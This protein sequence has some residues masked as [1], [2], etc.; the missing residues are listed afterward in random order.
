MNWEV[1]LDL[2]WTKACILIAHDNNITG[3]NFMVALV[4][5]Y[6]EYYF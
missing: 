1:E 5:D 3:T 2:S 6:N 4:D